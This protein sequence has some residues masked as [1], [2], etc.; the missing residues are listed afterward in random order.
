[1]AYAVGSYGDVGG[2]SGYT[3]A[4]L[5]VRLD[6]AVPRT[7]DEVIAALREL[8]F[9]GWVSEPEGGWLVTAAVRG[10][11]A[12]A[13]GGRD[14]VAAGA[15]VA[16]GLDVTVF[17][18][19]VLADRQLAIVAWSG[20]S[21]V[22]RYVSDPSYGRPREERVLDEP[23]GDEH[24]HA[25]ADAAGR[26]GAGD[27]LAEVLA[28][29]LDSDSYLE[30]ERLERVL[31]LLAMPDWLVSIPS[32][33]RDVPAGPA[34]SSFLRLGAGSDGVAGRVRG[35]GAD[36]VRKR[37]KQAPVVSDLPTVAEIDP[38]LL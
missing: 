32:L 19:R 3:Y 22:G 13:G 27:A 18:C 14:V 28:A 7:R 35:W 34:A 17:A 10:A 16:A 37:R 25:F 36:L 5:V 23:I 15:S 2:P 4:G 12:V 29:E 6:G 11:A 38:W 8:R 30:S 33:P 1:M 26:S 24:A 20:G 21:E 9:S 31:R